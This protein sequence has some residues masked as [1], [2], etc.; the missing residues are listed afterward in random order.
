MPAAPERPLEFPF[1]AP[2]APGTAT[3]IADGIDWIRMPLPFA[4]DHINLWLLEGGDGV[5]IVD[6]GYGDAA[7]RAL[8]EAH[9]ATT[10]RARRPCRIVV[11]H[12]HPD[13]VGNAA[14][15]SARFDLPVGMTHAEFLTAHALC[16]GHSGHGHDAIVA[17]FAQHGLAGE[18]LAGLSGR[19]NHYRRGAPEIP[20]AFTRIRDGEATPAGGRLWRVIEGHGHSPEH[21]SLYSAAAGVLISGDMLLPNISTN[22]GIWAIEPDADTLARFLDSLGAFEALPDDTLVLPSHGRPF[23]GIARRVAELRAHHAA[24]LDELLAAA[25]A[26]GGPISAC[27]LIPVLFRRE[28]DLQQ[29]FFA[30]GEAVAHLNHLWHAG[31]LTRHVG[32]GGAIRFADCGQNR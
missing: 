4:L 28:L 22:I 6:C 9:V 32:P 10:L 2:S 3:R 26:A 18:R 24:R 19:G 16:G 8:W 15:L 30:M 17:L 20:A 7:S 23:R 21:A 1:A 11:T 5:T 13:H 25:R 14:W 31:R 27:D 29:V 12:C